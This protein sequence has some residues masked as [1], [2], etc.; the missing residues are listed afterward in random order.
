MSCCLSEAPAASCWV[1]TAGQNPLQS[2]GCQ[3]LN[4]A[5]QQQP[6]QAMKPDQQEILLTACQSRLASIQPFAHYLLTTRSG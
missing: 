4:C 5:L 6:G 2:C 1:S 3:L